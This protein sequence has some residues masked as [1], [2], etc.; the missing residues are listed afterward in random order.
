[1]K[2]ENLFFPL[3]TVAFV[4]AFFLGTGVQESEG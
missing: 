1:M 2:R 3:Q 4:L